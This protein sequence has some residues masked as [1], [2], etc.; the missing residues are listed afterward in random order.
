MSVIE[1]RKLTASAG[2]ILTNGET[3]SEEVYLGKYDKPENWQEITKEEYEKI[4][5]E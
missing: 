4:L 3:Y 2:M 1:I 5:K